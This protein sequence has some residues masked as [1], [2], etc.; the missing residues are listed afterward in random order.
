MA[1]ASR[2]ALDLRQ[3]HPA[4]WFPAIKWYEQQ[5]DWVL[6]PFSSDSCAFNYPI[7][8]RIFGS[9]DAAALH[10]SLE[11]IVQRHEPL[12]SRFQVTNGV[13]QQLIAPASNVSFREVHHSTVSTADAEAR[14][15]DLCARESGYPFDLTQDTLL[16]AKL[17]ELSPT[18]HVLLI[19]THRIAFDDWSAGLLLREL[20]LLYPQSGATAPAAL[21]PLPY[22]Y[23]RFAGDLH[24][25][26]RRPEFQSESAYWLSKFRDRTVF[27]YL[28]NLELPG[29]SARTH[30]ARQNL[31]FN[32]QTRAR[33]E[34]VA[35]NAQATPFMVLAAILL[36]L[37]A[38][39]AA[40]PDTAI[41]CY[42]AN[43]NH[44]N[45]ETLIGP[46]ANRLILRANLA[47]ATTATAVLE[48]VRNAAL[49]AYSAQKLPHGEL[50]ETFSAAHHPQEN[51][52]TQ[53]A[54]M[55]SDDPIGNFE[56]PFL[57]VSE[58][59]FFAESTCHDLCIT[60]NFRRRGDLVID[61]LY[62]TALFDSETILTL[63][64]QYETA[65]H[66][67][68]DEYDGSAASTQRPEKSW[69]QTALASLASPSEPGPSITDAPEARLQKIWREIFSCSPIQ[70]ES[71]FFD[72]GGDS[73]AATRLLNAIESQ[74]G[75]RLSFADLWQCPTVRLL[76]A[77]LPS[78]TPPAQSTPEPAV[79]PAHSAAAASPRRSRRLWGIF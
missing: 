32:A 17:F 66:Q 26:L 57:T 62:R 51:P 54:M 36:R 35:S 74:F 22:S 43:R 79:S 24:Q 41:S 56:L 10:K 37:F 3:S 69:T 21:Q 2:T 65:L 45:L 31:W 23:S 50:L 55:M 75:V 44:A 8:L 52:R 15:R 14:V 60:P 9:I 38:T 34:R 47:G 71:S 1:S 46:F 48:K 72:L 29:S 13:L 20:S 61:F 28:D 42:A 68:L 59:P 19:V 30:G 70:L 7:A 25:Q 39:H 77:K 64:K 53:F 67:F 4:T 78:Q 73:L 11:V 27:E 76:A 63:V 58:F 6:H 40:D 18:D 16:R 5:R 49:Q 12:R 33:I